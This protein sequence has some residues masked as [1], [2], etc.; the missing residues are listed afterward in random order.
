M[1][2]AGRVRARACV[3]LVVATS[4]V[5]SVGARPGAAATEPSARDLSTVCDPVEVA[6][7][8]FAGTGGTHASAIDCLAWYGLAGGTGGTPFAPSEPIGRGEA[9]GLL[10]GV[11]GFAGGFGGGFGGGSGGP[12]VPPPGGLPPFTD[13]GASPHAGAIAELAELGVVAG[14]PDGSFRPDGELTREQL[15]LLL[16]RA[17]GP[18]TGSPPSGGGTSFGDVAG[19]P[20]E[21]A[22]QTLAEAGVLV[23]S[24]EGTFQPT[25]AATRGQVAAAAARFLA[26]LESEGVIA[27]GGVDITL[28]AGP[29]RPGATL[30]GTVSAGGSYAGT[31]ASGC[32]LREAALVVDASGRFAVTLSSDVPAGTC[33]LTFTSTVGDPARTDV[34]TVVVEV[35]PRVVSAP[36]FTPP[37]APTISAIEDVVMPEDEL[38]AD[39]VEFTVTPADAAVQVSS[40]D[41]TVIAPEGLALADVGGGAWTLAITPVADANGIVTVTVEV[42]DG[43]G[44]RASR[45]FDVTVV[46]VDDPPTLP[47]GA[48]GGVG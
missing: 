26:L 27:E 22:I 41:T 46:P 28:D 17:L 5:S 10:G 25:S 32:G 8:G 15:A 30:T 35:L 29:F 19:R 45:S 14:Y 36:V 9:A 6:D 31:V 38:S 4:L 37:P 20:A 23:G 43:A 16:V 39:L 11:L 2:G 34:D 47:T 3:A 7:A 48:G 33:T 42:T 24:G 12:G 21:G 40:S 18:V 44:N 13:T 1:V